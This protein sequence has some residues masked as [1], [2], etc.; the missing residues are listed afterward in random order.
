M[1]AGVD[2]AGRGA[3]IGNVVA[4]AVILPAHYDLPGLTDSK[5]LSARRREQLFT[6]ICEQAVAWRWAQA[7]AQEIDQLN[8]HH[9]TLL[10]MKRA[11][12]ALHCVPNEVLVDGKFVPQINIAARAVVGG[13]RDVPAIAAASIIA[14]VVRDRQMALLDVIYPH[15]GLLAHKGYPTKGH[16]TA[17]Q[18]HGI[19][20]LHR[21][22]YAP[23]KMIAAQPTLEL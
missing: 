11:V 5:K 8:I 19:C 14:K 2:E 9:A 21:L 16:I 22:S 10:A 3:L 12:L 20:A 18:A 4:A 15:Y 13:D 7:S 1:I 23:V 17:M 6:A